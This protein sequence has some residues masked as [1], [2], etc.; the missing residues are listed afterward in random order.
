M[1]RRL[2]LILCN[3]ARCVLPAARRSWADAMMAEL[4]HAENDP[5][6]LRFA[7]GCL[8]AALHA[9]AR[10]ADTRI[11]TG[12]WS[13]ATLTALF[14]LLQL[15]CA[16]RGM[17]VLLGAPDGMRDALVRY[18]AG[19]AVTASYEAA[20]PLVVGCFLAL[21]CAQFATAWFLS[22]GEI[23]P[24]LVAWSMALLI[25]GIAVAIQLSV[26]WDVE[27]IPSEFH[28]LL[29]QAVAVPALLAWSRHRQH[30]FRKG[31]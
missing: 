29:M 23:R 2:P 7:G 24:F 8:L 20:R 21:G 25:A 30:H 11:R 28:A 5:A 22:R 3:L 9:R 14:A 1:T 27:G 10:D 13:I 6:A 19:P 31:S 26:L 15:T 17:A 4:S 18:G 16:A 12:L